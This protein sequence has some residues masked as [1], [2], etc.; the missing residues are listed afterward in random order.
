ME[1]GNCRLCSFCMSLVIPLNLHFPLDLSL[2]DSAPL[3]FYCGDTLGCFV[4]SLA[5]FLKNSLPLFLKISQFHWL[6]AV[7][8][9]CLIPSS[10]GKY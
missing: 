9:N 5:L 8:L 10:S 7:F 4:N 1:D 2:S 3:Q 6:C